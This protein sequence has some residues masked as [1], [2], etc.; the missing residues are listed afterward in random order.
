MSTPTTNSDDSD[1]QDN[2]W[3][4]K[5]A[6]RLEELLNRKR[7]RVKPTHL[8]SG[9]EGEKVGVEDYL[10]AGHTPSGWRYYSDYATTAPR[11]R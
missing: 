4:R 11:Q 1:Y 7:A 2:P 3:V 8:P 10:A 6:E 5:A 9:P